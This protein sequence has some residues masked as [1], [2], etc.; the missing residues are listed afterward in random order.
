MKIAGSYAVPL[1]RERAYALLQ[2]PA[3]LAQCMP[4]CEA[5]DRVGEGE[6]AMRMKMKLASVSGLFDG[7]VKIGDPNPPFS[8]RM[9][10]EGSG[11]I[12]F[13]RGEGVITL[14]PAETGT[15][16]NYDGEVQV[17]GVIAN[18]GQRLIETTSKMLIKRFF[19]SLARKVASTAT[20]QGGERVDA[21]GAA[22]GDVTGQ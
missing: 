1:D 5:L 17:G 21:S 16:V 19:E 11:R 18:V 10:V 4:G 22:G 2:D 13:M 3:I 14:A 15:S 7:K 6:Y 8:Y 9:V 12:G 20:S